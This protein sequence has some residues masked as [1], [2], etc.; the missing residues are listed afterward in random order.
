MLI[1]ETH[2]TKNIYIKIPKYTLYE[3]QHPDGT[4]YGGTAII[5]RN[6]IKYRLHGH[7]NLEYLQAT[8]FIIE[9]WIGPQTIAAVYCPLKHTVK[10]EQ[11]RSFYDALGQR[12]LAGGDYNAKHSHRGSRL[13]APR[14][15]ELL[16]A[17]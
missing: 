9:D 2:F 16:R 4:A 15:Q 1:W 17:M 5:I 13:T 12:F 10:A 3:T 11:F 6:C 14:G 7:Y 8:S